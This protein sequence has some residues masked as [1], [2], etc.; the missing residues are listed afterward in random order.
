MKDRGSKRLGGG[1]EERERIRIRSVKGHS[2]GLRRVLE[3]DEGIGSKTLT[4]D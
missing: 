4:R 2:E 3:R 1:L